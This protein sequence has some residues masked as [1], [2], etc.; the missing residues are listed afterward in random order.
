MF[1]EKATN[2][3]ANYRWRFMG[4]QG[5]LSGRLF[6]FQ[7]TS[8]INACV[9]RDEW[10]HLQIYCRTSFFYAVTLLSNL[11]IIMDSSFR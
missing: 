1:F 10:T 7:I 9:D 2:F 11:I 5:T 6:F 3:S 8:V 4:Y